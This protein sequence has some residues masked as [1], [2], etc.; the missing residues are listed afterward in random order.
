MTTFTADSSTT[1]SSAWMP[2]DGLIQEWGAFGAEHAI[3]GPALHAV[4]MAFCA[5]ARETTARIYYTP[6]G[7][8]RWTGT[9]LSW[10]TRWRSCCPPGSTGQTP[11]SR[12]NSCYLIHTRSRRLGR[13]STPCWSRC[14]SS[15]C[16]WRCSST[17]PSRSNW[18]PTAV[19]NATSR[20]RKRPD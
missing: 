9:L 16:G 17:R 6:P 13:A 4:G 10:N 1:L 15:V 14:W 20:E 12:S 5:L 2:L 7:T 19:R 18:R 3:T 8:L 11:C